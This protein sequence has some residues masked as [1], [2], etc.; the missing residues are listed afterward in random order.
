MNKTQTRLNPEDQAKVDRFLKQGVN[1]TERSSFK[2]W[3]LMLWLAVVIIILGILSRFIGS[4]V[5]G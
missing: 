1:A 4:F 2:P 5:L 3:R